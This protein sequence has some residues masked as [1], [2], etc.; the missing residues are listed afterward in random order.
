[1]LFDSHAH[2]Q[3]PKFRGDLDAVL[4]RA[5][6]AGVDRILNL[7]TRL[8]DSH[9]VL[10]LARAHVECLAAVGVHPGDLDAWS[11]EEERG[12]LELAASPDV[13]VYGE[14]GLDYFRNHFDRETQ[15]PI[16]R[17]QLAMAREL[18]LPVAIHCREAYEDLIADL[19]AEN[20]ATIGGV[21]HCF[22]G[23]LEDA[24]AL[25]DLGFALGAGGSATFPKSADLREILVA[26]GPGHLLLETDSPY[27]APQARRGQRNEPSF[28]ALTAEALAPL[29]DL[30]PAEL[31][32]LA[33]ANTIR[34]FRLNADATGRA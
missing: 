32:A 15:R 22:S 12:L 20:G 28:V 6:A 1:M 5:R 24:H 29:F 33:R 14:I 7:G 31:A 10:A 23:T 18:G 21:A 19:R 17:R 4:D 34:A 27:L 30:E 26:I 11:P 13:V 8:A 3:N 9:E 16:F 2:L 25:I